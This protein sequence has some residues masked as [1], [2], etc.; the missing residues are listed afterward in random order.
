[1][2]LVFDHVIATDKGKEIIIDK[3]VTQD[4][5]AVY[6]DLVAH[7]T[8]SI[9]AK[10]KADELREYISGVQY[11]SSW[12][13]NSSSFIKHWKAKVKEYNELQVNPDDRLS[14]NIKLTML[15]TAVRHVDALHR[16]KEMAVNVSTVNNTPLTYPVY[17]GLLENASAQHDKDVVDTKQKGRSANYHN[18]RF[19][20]EGTHI[21]VEEDKCEDVK[22][23]RQHAAGY[24]VAT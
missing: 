18:L 5:Q 24:I 16:I 7:Y 9:D 14:D 1:M 3:D 20:N 17:L 6:R 8:T 13:G 10:L 11:S 21:A 12:K 22:R 4:G 2:Y 23:D 19:I 15:Q